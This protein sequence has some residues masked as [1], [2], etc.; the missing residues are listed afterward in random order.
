MINVVI[1]GKELIDLGYKPGKWFKS[2]IDFANQHQLSGD[3]LKNYL[4]TVSPKYIEPHEEPV[5]FYQNIKAETE[6]EVSNIESV[7][8]TMKELMRTPTIVGGAVMPDACPTGEG[9][10][11]VGAIVVARNAIHPSMHSADVCCSVMMTNV[12]IW[13]WESRERNYALWLYYGR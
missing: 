8:S 10:I 12:G 13:T 3:N 2:A 7:L 1:S 9:Q 11:P 5:N 6:E 4:V